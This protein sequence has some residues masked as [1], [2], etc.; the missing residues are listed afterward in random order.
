GKP[1]AKSKD[2]FHFLY[3]TLEGDGE[4]RARL[5]DVELTHSLAKAGVLIR[6]NLKPNS[7]HA[8]LYLRAGSGVEF[9]HRSQ[10][11]NKT[12]WAGGEAAPYWLRLTRHGEWV[13]AYKSADGLVWNEIGSDRVKMHRKIYVGLAVSSWNNSKLT[14]SIFDNVNVVPG[15]SNSVEAVA[16]E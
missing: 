5:V 13:Y 3:Q 9:E 2:Q 14:T 4:I 16:S 10:S 15:A 6:D 8:F 11:E 1:D 7:P 12:D